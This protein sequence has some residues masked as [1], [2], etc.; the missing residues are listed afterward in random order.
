M[1]FIN[2][3]SQSVRCFVSKDIDFTLLP[4]EQKEIDIEGNSIFVKLSHLYGSS[5]GKCFGWDKIYQIVLNT[6]F[7]LNNAQSNSIIVIKREKVHFELGY[8]YDR[9]YAKGKNCFCSKIKYDVSNYEKLSSDTML[10]IKK[11]DSFL[12]RVVD[13][14]FLGHFLNTSVLFIM[15]KL[16]FLANERSFPWWYITLFWTAGYAIQILSEKVFYRFKNNR[17]PQSL[18]DLEKYCS[19]E[20]IEKYFGDSKRSWIADDIELE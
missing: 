17:K 16:A 15:F 9:L 5:V 7:E 14:I 20:Y 8:A 18:T 11:K 19:V 13:F 6:L 2:N 3:S 1:L 4:N 10:T 12:E